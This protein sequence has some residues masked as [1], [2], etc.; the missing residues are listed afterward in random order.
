M[1]DERTLT[2]KAI[3]EL[4]ERRE[5]LTKARD[6]AV[7]RYRAQAAPMRKDELIAAIRADVERGRISMR[8]TGKETKQELL[9]KSARAY[10]NANEHGATLARLE[11]AALA[12]QRMAHMV[13]AALD[14]VEVMETKLSWEVD[15]DFRPVRERTTED[16]AYQ[17]RRH[18]D[19]F[20]VAVARA[21]YA[22]RVA[23]AVN[24]GD[25]IR[26]A[27][28]RVARNAARTIMTLPNRLLVNGLGGMGRSESLFDAAGAQEFLR[29][30]VRAYGFLDDEDD[31]LVAVLAD[32]T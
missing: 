1:I 20:Q 15:G 25:D 14:Y 18:G 26:A 8:L 30:V 3:R 4:A 10:A 24:D 32:L 17:M 28:M 23:E 29:T 6:A 9:D 31:N 5:A 12:D 7:E 22:K 2:S 16:K 13:A 21:H 27:T 19:D 11:A